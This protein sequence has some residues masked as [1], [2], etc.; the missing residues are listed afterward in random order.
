MGLCASSLGP[1]APDVS[2][3]YDLEPLPDIDGNPVEF[4]QFKGKVSRVPSSSGGAGA[5]AGGSRRCPQADKLPTAPLPY[6]P[7]RW[8]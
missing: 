8:C 3:F 5:E 6:P 2:S 7:C 4:A 1:A